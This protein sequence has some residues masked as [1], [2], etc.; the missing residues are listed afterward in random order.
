MKTL[1]QHIKESLNESDEDPSHAEDPS[2]ANHPGNF[3]TRVLIDDTP[4]IDTHKEYVKH[5]YDI[6]IPVAHLS[7]LKLKLSDVKRFIEQHKNSRYLYPEYHPY[8][9]K[10]HVRAVLN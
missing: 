9:E 10:K 4:D 8:I 6:K 1:L 5:G 3:I 7:K 2:Y